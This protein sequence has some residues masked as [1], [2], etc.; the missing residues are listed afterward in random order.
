MM[1]ISKPSREVGRDGS[2]ESVPDA[3]VRA[4]MIAGVLE[5]VILY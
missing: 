4:A 1:A 3:G 2:E 5:G